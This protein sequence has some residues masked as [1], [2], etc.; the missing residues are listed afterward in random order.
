[1]SVETEGLQP[2]GRFARAIGLTIKAFRHYS[3]IGLLRPARVDEWT[4][5]GY[6]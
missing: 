2:I 6:H 1:M 3:E 4:G 5:Y